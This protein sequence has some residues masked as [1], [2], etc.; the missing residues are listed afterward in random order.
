MQSDDSIVLPILIKHGVYQIFPS[1]SSAVKCMFS[2]NIR[3]PATTHKV[4]DEVT[5]LA[6]IPGK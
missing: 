2:Q 5:G 4:L 3:S 6:Q 1:G